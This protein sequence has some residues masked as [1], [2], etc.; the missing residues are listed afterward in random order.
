M[1]KKK[2]QS[3]DSV[4]TSLNKEVK[5]LSEENRELRKLLQNEIA[6][7]SSA[8]M[9][10]H[11]QLNK[12]NALIDSIPWLV[13]WVTPD[14]YYFDT[15]HFYAEKLKSDVNL[16]VNRKI[17]SFNKNQDLLNTLI[18]FSKSTKKTCVREIKF[19]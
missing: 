4:I 17:G 3:N 9:A 18:S 12:E 5:K 10:L 15:N 1:V 6:N 19:I 2:I 8:S 13:F 7:K 16:I 14:L 11:Y